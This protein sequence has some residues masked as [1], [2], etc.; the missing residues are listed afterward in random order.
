MWKHIFCVLLMLSKTI[1]YGFKSIAFCRG[2]INPLSSRCGLIA[3]GPVLPVQQ[4]RVAHLRRGR[5]AMPHSFQYHT[6]EIEEIWH[7]Q[8]PI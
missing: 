3:Q 7:L 6:G 4:V 5:P 2:P 8:N 1:L